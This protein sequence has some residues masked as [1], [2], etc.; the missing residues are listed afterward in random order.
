MGSLL[1]LSLEH[2]ARA[3]ITS[4]PKGSLPGEVGSR[5][6][7]LEGQ[8]FLGEHGEGELDGFLN[9]DCLA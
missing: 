9:W 5:G 6:Y 7:S 4:L 3:T 1:V 2:R 8:H